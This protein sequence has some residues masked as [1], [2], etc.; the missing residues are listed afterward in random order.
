M[1]LGVVFEDFTHFEAVHDRHHHIEQDEVWPL[2]V[3]LLERFR[4]I[5]GFDHLVAAAEQQYLQDPDIISLVIDD[6][7]FGL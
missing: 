6:E 3:H 4:S 2:A 5:P 7:D 1:C